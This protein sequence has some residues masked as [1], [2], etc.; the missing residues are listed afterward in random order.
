MGQYLVK[1]LDA[2]FI[3]H[4]VKRFIVEKPPEY[5]FVPGQG[6]EVAI[7][8]PEWKDKLRPF[9][10]TNLN[11]QNY[12]ELMV[13]IYP[14]RKGVTYQLGKTNA[15]AELIIG[16]PFGAINYKGPGVFLAGGS[17][18]TPFLSIFRHLYKAQQLRGN[19]LIYSNR[20]VEDVIMFQELQKMLKTDLI[21]FFSH[22]N[23]IGFGYNRID[24][25]YLIAAIKDFSQYFYLCGPDAFVKDL[26]KILM[27][28]GANL[29]SLVIEE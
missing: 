21:P 23:K 27:D 19:K 28:L 16:E 25:N 18:I 7:N 6:A 3:N 2:E 1:I 29:E 22:E 12:L 24:R 13:K 14:A 26:S 5:V 17:G 4:D 10:F 9:T 15:G 8:L 11:S 20:T